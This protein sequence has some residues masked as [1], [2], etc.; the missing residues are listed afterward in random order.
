MGY[1]LL[2][3]GRLV[4]KAHRLL[5]RDRES[6]RFDVL[7]DPYAPSPPPKALNN[8]AVAFVSICISSSSTSIVVIMR[9]LINR[10]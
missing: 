3:V 1:Q 4:A 10:S 7:I 8:L 2:F 9:I 5:L 6:N